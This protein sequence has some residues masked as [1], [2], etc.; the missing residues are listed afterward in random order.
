M[1]RAGLGALR[2]GEMPAEPA[3]KG[4][5]GWGPTERPLF[6]GQVWNW[7]F[8]TGERAGDGLSWLMG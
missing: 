4:R 2:E 7:F 3:G 5:G 6:S 1:G 8:S